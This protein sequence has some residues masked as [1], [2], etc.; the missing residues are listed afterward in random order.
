VCLFFEAEANKS[1]DAATNESSKQNETE[2]R[3]KVI[4]DPYKGRPTC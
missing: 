3:K 2:V 1:Q 4:V